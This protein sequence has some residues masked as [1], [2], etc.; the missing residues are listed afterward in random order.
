MSA[1]AAVLVIMY[2]LLAPLAGGLMEGVDRK[3]SARMQGRIGPPVLQPFYDVI[4]LFNKQVI[5]VGIFQSALLL[6]YLVLMIFT[7]AIFFAG[8][9]ILMCLFVLTTASTFMY[10]AA[11][12]T[13]SPYNT[14]ASSRELIQIMTYE[15]AV[16]MAGVGQDAGPVCLFCP[17]PSHQDEKVTLRR[18]HIPSRPPGAGHGRQNRDGSPESG[19]LYDH[20]VV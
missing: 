14:I 8:S 11:V 3:I 5:A 18:Q 13:S 17:D 4:K 6:C 15:P 20:G 12:V 1:K 2:I 7:G 19:D 10:F 16:L 9:D